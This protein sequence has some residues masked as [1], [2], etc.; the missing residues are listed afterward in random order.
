M[1]LPLELSHLHLSMYLGVTTTTT[2]RCSMVLEGNG[3]ILQMF[4][5]GSCFC[6]EGWSPLIGSILWILVHIYTHTNATSFGFIV[7]H[8]IR[9]CWITRAMWITRSSNLARPLHYVLLSKVTIGGGQLARGFMG[10]GGRFGKFIGKEF[11][12]SLSQSEWLTER[13][14]L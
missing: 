10:W 6:I 2:C 9:W 3:D 4:K 8:E 13:E 7:A 5:V 11:E 14:V 1:Y 12:A